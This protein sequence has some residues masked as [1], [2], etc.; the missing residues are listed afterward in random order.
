MKKEQRKGKILEIWK[1]FQTP[2]SNEEVTARCIAENVWSSEERSRMVMR[3]ARAEVRDTLN[4]QDTSRQ[5]LALTRY[6]DIEE[7]PD[8]NVV[9]VK[10][11]VQPEFWTEG[12]AE[13]WIKDRGVQLQQDFDKVRDFIDGTCRDRWPE[14]DWWAMVPLRSKEED[15]PVE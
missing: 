1:S 4:E 3:A 15:S 10:H 13:T 11:Y 14:R 9:S 7:G 2:V 8:G 5:P 6:I 12:D